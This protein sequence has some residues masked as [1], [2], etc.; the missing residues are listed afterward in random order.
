MVVILEAL[1]VLASSGFSPKDTLEFHF[2]AGEEGGMLGSQAVFAN[3]KSAGKSILAVVNQ[4]MAGYSPS[5][6]VSIYTDYVDSSLTAYVRLVATQYTG[7]STTSDVCGYG[8][9]DHVS[10]RSN[11]FRESNLLA[12]VTQNIKIPGINWRVA[13]AYVCDEVMATSS[14]Y[15]H[16]SADVRSPMPPLTCFADDFNSLP[17]SRTRQLCGMLCFGILSSLLV[18]WSRLRISKLRVI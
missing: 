10:A 15:I 12:C 5:G 4:D 14:P 18:S 13:A 1:R 2:Y 7:T 9:S 6:K 16:S 3:Y 11:G 8:C 17:H